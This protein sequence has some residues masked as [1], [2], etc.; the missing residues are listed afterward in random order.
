MRISFAQDTRFQHARQTPHG[1]D[2][3]RGMLEI[4]G[5]KVAP[6]ELPHPKRGRLE[7]A[8]SHAH[9]HLDTAAGYPWFHLSGAMA[10]PEWVGAGIA[11]IRRTPSE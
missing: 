11:E 1:R 7:I 9:A 8:P 5:C 10:Q 4:I 6:I 2:Y 3:H